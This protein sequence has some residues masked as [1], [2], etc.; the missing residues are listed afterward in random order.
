MPSRL[1]SGW[2]TELIRRRATATA[3]AISE[4]HTD[5]VRGGG[6]FV[7]GE[8]NEKTT[9][10]LVDHDSPLAHEG[11]ERVVTGKSSR[12]DVLVVVNQ[13]I[14]ELLKA[15][16]SRSPSTSTQP[17]AVDCSRPVKAGIAAK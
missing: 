15:A 7:V 16:P 17:A 12:H 2:G 5:T 8:T 14:E 9:D 10:R 11:R 1:A 6:R 13:G 3:E 4:R